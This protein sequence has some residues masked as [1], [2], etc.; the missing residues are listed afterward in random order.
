VKQGR[1]MKERRRRT[2][3]MS[4]SNHAAPNA[5]LYGLVYIQ[6]KYTRTHTH[7]HIYIYI[8]THVHVNRKDVAA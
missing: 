6:R 2:T 1:K 7:T 8:N 3:H 4:C 5:L